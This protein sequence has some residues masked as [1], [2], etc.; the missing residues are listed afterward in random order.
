MGAQQRQRP[1]VLLAREVRLRRAEDRRRGRIHGAS[2]RQ[3]DSENKGRR[4]APS[5]RKEESSSEGEMRRAVRACPSRRTSSSAPWESVT[6]LSPK[7]MAL[8]ARS[9]REGNRHCALWGVM[10]RAACGPRSPQEDQAAPLLSEGAGGTP[11]MS[12]SCPLSF[13]LSN[14]YSSIEKVRLA[15]RPRA[16]T[17]EVPRQAVG[18]EGPQARQ[19]DPLVHQRTPLQNPPTPHPRSAQ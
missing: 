19:R 14:A 5:P 7:K 13:F 15:T 12:A 11:L 2:R 8:R 9:E 1:P 6:S 10:A 17:Y 16:P 3:D 18:D 4:L